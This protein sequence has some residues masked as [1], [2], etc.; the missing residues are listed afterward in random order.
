MMAPFQGSTH[1]DAA[2][3]QGVA[4]GYRRSPLRGC[5]G[6]SHSRSARFGRHVFDDADDDA[7][8]E[9]LARDRAERLQGVAP[10]SV[11]LRRRIEVRH[12]VLAIP[13]AFALRRRDV[14]R[15]IQRVAAGRAD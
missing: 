14:E 9:I 4:L 13:D 11:E 2:W 6:I 12:R 15:L 7:E 3:T 8:A 5:C 1:S 10:E